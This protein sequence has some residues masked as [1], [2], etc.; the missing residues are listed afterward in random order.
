MVF[1]D[2]VTILSITLLFF[3]GFH[4]LVIIIALVQFDSH[5]GYLLWFPWSLVM[6]LL[7]SHLASI[8]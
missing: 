1:C 3:L 6:L 8:Y 4:L 5:N 7:N 2:I